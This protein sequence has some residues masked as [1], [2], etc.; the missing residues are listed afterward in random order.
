MFT[1]Q[2][3]GVA[4]Q[5][6]PRKQIINIGL[7]NKQASRSEK[8]GIK[9]AA[10]GRIFHA[11]IV[12]LWGSFLRLSAVYEPPVHLPSLCP[13]YRISAQKRIRFRLKF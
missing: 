3:S 9:P 7:V 6:L 12:N 1:F 11:Y 8:R 5:F 2:N 4:N 10:A 13:G